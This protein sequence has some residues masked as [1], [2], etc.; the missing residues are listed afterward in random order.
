MESQELEAYGLCGLRPAEF[1]ALTLPEYQSVLEACYWREARHL[2]LLAQ[3]LAQLLRPY[4]D[5]RTPTEF[6]VDDLLGGDP[7][8]KIEEARATRLAEIRKARDTEAWPSR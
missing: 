2:R 6:F 8:A 3:S 7:V 1:A 5:E 4:L